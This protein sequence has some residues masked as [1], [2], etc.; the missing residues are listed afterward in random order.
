MIGIINKYESGSAPEIKRNRVPNT[1]PVLHGIM[2][3]VCSSN[4]DRNSDVN[5]DIRQGLMQISGWKGVVTNS[6]VL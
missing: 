5:K 6:L 3:P 2:E 4:L 1:D